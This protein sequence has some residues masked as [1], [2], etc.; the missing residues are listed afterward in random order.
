MRSAPIA[1]DRLYRLLL[2][3]VGTWAAGWLEWQVPN[4]LAD[5]HIVAPLAALSFAV[6]LRWGNALWPL[7][8]AAAV[9]VALLV[10][11]VHWASLA[12]WTLAS[13]VAPWLGVRFYRRTE[14]AV[15]IIET[16]NVPRLTMAALVSALAAAL[17]HALAWWVARGGQWELLAAATGMSLLR[18]TISGVILPLMALH[19]STDPRALGTILRRHWRPTVQALGACALTWALAYWGLTHPTAPPALTWLW[20][21]L[22]FLLVGWVAARSLS[23]A[24]MALLGILGV[25]IAPMLS[26]HAPFGRVPGALDSTLY[27]GM[28]WSYMALLTVLIWWVH[29][30]AHRAAVADVRWLNTLALTDTGVAQ[31]LL[32][33]DEMHLSARWWSWLGQTER[34]PPQSSRAV[35]LRI[36]DE[37]RNPVREFLLGLSEHNLSVG[38]IEFRMQTLQSDWIWLQCHAVLDELTPTGQPL[39]ITLTVKDVTT[40]RAAAEKQLLSNAIFEHLP[41]AVLITD[42]QFR[43]LDFNARLAELVGCTRDDTLGRVPGLLKAL[44]EPA[45]L[46]AMPTDLLLHGQWRG[47]IRTQGRLGRALVFQTTAC[48]TQQQGELRLCAFVLSDI[49]ERLQQKEQLDRQARFDELTGL[50]NRVSLGSLLREAIQA[51]EREG[52]LLTIC[53]FD[54]DHF[55]GVNDKFG[56][57]TGDALLIAVSQRLAKVASLP[58]DHLPAVAR[59]GGDEFTL[60]LRSATLEQSRRA[61]ERV[62]RS[63]A[64]PFEIAGIPQPLRIT[65]SIGATVYPI[66]SADADTLLRHADQAMYRAKQAGRNGYLFFDAELDRR[67]EAHFEALAH[68]QQA[69]VDEQFVL[70]FQPKVNMRLNKVLGVEALLRW[71]HPRHGVIPPA[72]FLPLIEPTPLSEEVGAWVLEKG[73]DQLAQWQ[74]LGLDLTLSINVSARH[75]QAPSFKQRLAEHLSRHPAAVAQGLILEVLETAALANI[76]Y[77]SQL[78]DECKALGVRFALDDFG[79]GYSTLTYLKRLPL[80]LLKI[81]RS[82]VHNMLNDN[83]DM[84][85]VQGVIGLSQTFGCVVVAEG[86]ESAEQARQLIAAG[87]EIGQGNGI[88]KAMP[89]EEV[90]LWIKNYRGVVALPL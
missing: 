45:T 69:L 73:I 21:G 11:G 50:P 16:L 88:A 70:Y 72:Q 1:F 27:W 10:P 52:F 41:E 71:K 35:W 12:A 59:L 84:A 64:L 90:P 19:W 83:Q 51:S 9:L 67:K 17:T 66:D 53:S 8:A 32:D 62:L 6:L 22:I 60:L 36:H 47:E 13:T 57:A 68:V 34:Q 81:D 24:S 75:L 87:C 23:A 89:A 37:D 15:A 79:T 3:G 33:T 40:Q 78:M 86:V 56:H 55:K 46:N 49:T 38:P 58:Q 29:A 48:A 82:F 74:Q 20:G 31:W 28:V 2:L 80:D 43:A 30:Q 54:L 85:I 44:V 42:G 63:I 4:P 65:G 26:G 5:I 25:A 14:P 76:D 7:L 61:V 18:D 77:T 39:R